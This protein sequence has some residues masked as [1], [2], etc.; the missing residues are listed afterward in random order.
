MKLNVSQNTIE[1]ILNIAFSDGSI[2]KNGCKSQ[3]L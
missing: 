2:N 3:M 1:V